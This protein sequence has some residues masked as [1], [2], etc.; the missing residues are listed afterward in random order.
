MT[1]FR[2][3]CDEL[4]AELALLDEPPHHL[5]VRAQEALAEPQPPAEGEVAEL[6]AWLRNLSARQGGLFNV[7]MFC[8]NL[9]RAAD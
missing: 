6:V 4:V 7:A 5:V 2:A 9:D 8:A 1:D 3:L